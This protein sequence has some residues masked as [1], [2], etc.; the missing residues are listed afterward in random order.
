M[1][2]LLFRHAHKGVMPFNDPELSP[3]GLEQAHHLLQMIQNN[4]LAKPTHLYVS[5]RKRAHQTF[6]AIAQN[7]KIKIESDANLDQRLSTES[8]TEFRKRIQNF[9][10]HL[11]S[12]AKPQTVAFACSH[13][14]WL[15][16][17]MNLINCNQ[18]LNTFEYSHWAPTQYLE[19]E[20]D[21]GIWKLIGKGA[22]Q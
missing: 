8:A 7:F 19:F 14:D 3:Q 12:T 10:N 20:W 13:Y 18:N 6:S 2:F 11:E 21:D 22:S 17:A 16:E 5:P 9:M 15:E 4:K 1:K